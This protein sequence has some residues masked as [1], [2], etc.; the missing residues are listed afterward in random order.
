MAGVE[1]C[2]MDVANSYLE[3]WGHRLGA[4]HRPFH[5]EAFV[6]TLFG[7]P[8]AV[9][10]SASIVSSTVAEFRRQDVVECARLCSAPGY[11]WASRIMLRL[12]REVCVACWPC[13]EVKAA[14]SYSQNAHHSGNLYRFDGWSKAS[15]QAGSRGG[16]TWTHTR[17][18][19]DAAAGKKT[20][21][22]WRYPMA[23]PTADQLRALHPWFLWR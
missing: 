19:E 21:W 22:I 17:S 6:F 16:G 23:A 20:L 13:W 7:Q 12:W 5:A 8:I 14:V 11:A 15:E 3:S 1:C 10:V 18:P 4:I 2:D 9:A